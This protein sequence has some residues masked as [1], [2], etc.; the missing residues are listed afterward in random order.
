MWK[1]WASGVA[2]EFGNGTIAFSNLSLSIV[3]QLLA[4]HDTRIKCRNID[5]KHII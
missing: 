2:A 5:S 1:V 4:G 3:A